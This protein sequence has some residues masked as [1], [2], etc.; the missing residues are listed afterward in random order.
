M[1]HIHSAVEPDRRA[2]HL[3]KTISVSHLLTTVAIAGSV[4]V[5]ASKMEQRLS[6]LETRVE[7]SAQSV[8]ATQRDV[9]E[10]AQV[11]RDEVRMLRM[12]VREAIRPTRPQP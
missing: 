5:W 10:L 3:D 12:E 6:V 8:T 4:F 2:W 7:H 1:N 9:K 11:V